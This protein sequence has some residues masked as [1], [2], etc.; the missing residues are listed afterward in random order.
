MNLG[1]VFSSDL[2]WRS[3]IAHIFH[4]VN[5]SLYK[6]KYYRNSFFQSLKIK[7]ISTLIFPSLDSCCLFY[8]DLTDELNLRL[9]VF[10]NNCIRFIFYL[11]RDVH[12]TPYR[13]RL[14]GLSVS[15]RRL[16]VLACSTYR[17]FHPFYAPYIRD[18][19]LVHLRTPQR[20][21]R[22]AA[23]ARIF[24]VPLHRTT[25]CENSFLISSFRLWNTLPQDMR[26]ASPLPIFKKLLM[27]IYYRLSL[28][29]DRPGDAGG[30][31]LFL[32]RTASCGGLETWL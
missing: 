15:N 21:L 16:Y 2:S 13:L 23:P 27:T 19:F 22:E 6:L 26:G 11:R 14:G 3:H 7:L 4:K 8:H 17:V 12:I 10:M 25:T 29:R 1:I 24:A 18:E 31:L 32:F 28:L 5:Y 9:Q 20:P 30:I